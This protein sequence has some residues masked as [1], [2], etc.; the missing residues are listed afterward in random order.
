MR[1]VTD[2]RSAA[3]S[4]IE[5]DQTADNISKPPPTDILVV[6]EKGKW[7][8]YPQLTFN[9]LFRDRTTSQWQFSKA[10]TDGKLRYL[11]E[12]RVNSKTASSLV[13]GILNSFE[14]SH[15]G[16][17]ARQKQAAYRSFRTG[18]WHDPPRAPEV[19]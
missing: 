14:T 12:P 4:T 17:M 13:P 5:S 3:V 19:N 1:L 8:V 18:D 16:A 9:T 6:S 10:Y 2:S 7:H 15:K 11:A